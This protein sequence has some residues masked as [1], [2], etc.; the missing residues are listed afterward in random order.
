MEFDNRDVHKTKQLFLSLIGIELSNE[1]SKQVL[2]NAEK[3]YT[4]KPIEIEIETEVYASECADDKKARRLRAQMGDKSAR[5]PKLEKVTAE[6]KFKIWAI[7]FNFSVLPKVVIDWFASYLEVHEVKKLKK[8]ELDND[9]LL[10]DDKLYEMPLILK[11]II[12][13]LRSKDDLVFRRISKEKKP[14]LLDF[15]SER[16]AALI[17]QGDEETLIALEKLMSK[18]ENLKSMVNERVENLDNIKFKTKKIKTEK[19]Q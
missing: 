16:I 8:H 10:K 9:F 19:I 1:E 6:R 17:K 3:L 12:N 15:T 13:G 7:E 4:G 18:D 2:K 11:K 5:V 14:S